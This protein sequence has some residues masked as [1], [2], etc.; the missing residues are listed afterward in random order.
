MAKKVTPMDAILQKQLTAQFFE[1][2]IANQ[3][4]LQVRPQNLRAN[5]L[6]SIRLSVTN[7]DT[8]HQKDMAVAVIEEQAISEQ[9]LETIGFDSSMMSVYPAAG[10]ETI[11]QFK[12]TYMLDS[13][14]FL[15]Q[16][17][18][19]I[20]VEVQFADPSHSIFSSRTVH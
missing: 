14:P 4:Q 3:S 17:S 2:T 11:T 10:V 18:Q 13:I 8:T 6:Y 7:A 1:Q 20:R 15:Q 5:A 19:A 16:L 12:V 9:P